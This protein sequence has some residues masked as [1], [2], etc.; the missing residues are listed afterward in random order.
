MFSFVPRSSLRPWS[1]TRIRVPLSHG[2]PYCDKEH[3]PLFYCY[4]PSLKPQRHT[5]EW[6][7][8]P[9]MVHSH[10]MLSQC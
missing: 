8:V 10:L 2:G 5:R 7:L 6:D 3:R 4:S 1:F 9:L